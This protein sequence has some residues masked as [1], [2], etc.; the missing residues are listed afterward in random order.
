MDRDLWTR[1]GYDPDKARLLAGLRQ[2]DLINI[3]FVV[4]E[5][6]QKAIAFGCDQDWYGSHWQRQAGCGPCTSATLLLYLA[7]SRKELETLYPHSIQ[8]QSFF[9][10]FMDQIWTYVTPGHMGVNESSI[11]VNGIAK[12]AASHSIALESNVFPIPGQ[13][14]RRKPIDT[15]LDFI[16]EG[17]QLDSP[18][19]FLNLSNGGL[20]NLDSWHW[21]V[22]TAVHLYDSELLLAEVSDSG[23]RKLINLSLW[24]S[25]SRLGGAAVYFQSAGTVA[26]DSSV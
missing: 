9:T 20:T 5:T 3:P 7:R 2:A 14:N 16:L 10:G 26:P 1:A 13:K 8:D 25:T 4:L 19:A 15:F 21:I 22:I 11:L 18:V 6:G 17:L 12:Y 23:E 24:Y